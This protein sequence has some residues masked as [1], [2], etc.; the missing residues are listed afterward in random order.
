[1]SEWARKRFWQQARVVPEHGGYAVAL[2]QRMLKTPAKAP[3]R[4]PTLAMA[5][6]AA[7]EWDDLEG[8]IDPQQMPVTRAVNAAI[9]KVAPQHAE[10]AALVA[11]YGESDLLCYRAAGPAPLIAR[12]A[13]AWDPLLARAAR[14][15]GA[16]L[17]V[18]TGVVHRPQP[19]QS[20]ARLRAIV[21]GQSAF[22]L[23]ALHDLVALS[24]SLI[25]GLAAIRGWDDTTRLWQVS[26][27]DEAWQQQQWG[28]D[29][30]A[31]ELAETKRRDFLRAH[32]FFVFAQNCDL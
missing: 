8:P 26:R 29:R 7:A 1:V 17:L 19:D 24:G 27:L 15:L 21:A 32:R 20:L 22:E 5:R 3:F 23:T 30:D 25:I 9:D 4:V 28:K 18:T 16:P 12:Q 2:D 31:V 11:E 10:V 6:A 14:E 13:A